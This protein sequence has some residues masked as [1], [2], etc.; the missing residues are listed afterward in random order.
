MNKKE[1]D[2][3]L[4][5]LCLAAG[6]DGGV[7]TISG[8][9][10]FNSHGQCRQESKTETIIECIKN[11]FDNK[12]WEDNTIEG[13]VLPFRDDCLLVYCPIIKGSKPLGVVFLIV[14]DVGDL[15]DTKN[16]SDKKISQCLPLVELT[17]ELI[18]HSEK[19]KE[20]ES[21]KYQLREYNSEQYEIVADSI[22]QPL[23]DLNLHGMI[24][25][26]NKSAREKLN[27]SDKEDIQRL[28]FTTVFDKT[29]QQRVQ[30]QFDKIISGSYLQSNDFLL[31]IQ[32]EYSRSAS[33]MLYPAYRR[34][35]LE[36]VRVLFTEFNVGMPLQ[37]KLVY[38]DATLQ[39]FFKAAPVGLAIIKERRVQSM[40]RR[41]VDITG[42]SLK[43]LR[44][45]STKVLYDGRDEYER[46]EKTVY[47]NILPNE[48][49]Y[50]ETRFRTKGGTLKHISV[51]A[52]AIS[53][54]PEDGVAVVIQDI[55]N[56]EDRAGTAIKSEVSQ[57]RY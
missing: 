12:S 42:Y 49:R 25:Y 48:S 1:I 21:Q 30:R 36:S 35:K 29:D 14:S 20:L 43:E 31:N 2:S 23:L 9:L 56:K 55:T 34:N 5:K 13:A 10:Y 27:L 45:L 17:A 46:V 8:E 41:F 38:S 44:D 28:H 54:N 53:S 33:I 11:E 39:G 18:S 4:Q 19:I 24:N 16:K 51:Y 22:S 50:I 3:S 40:N 32:I 52:S 6:F 37:D 7:L 57:V 15:S 47:E 26:A